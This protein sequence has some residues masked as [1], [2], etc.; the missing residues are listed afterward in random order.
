MYGPNAARQLPGPDWLRTQRM[1]AAAALD[2][3]GLPSPDEEVWRYSRI[4]ELE[5]DLYAPM[6]LRPPSGAPEGAGT[7]IDTL[8]DRAA[9]VVLHDGFVVHAELDHEVASKGAAIGAMADVPGDEADGCR[10]V[11][12]VLGMRWAKGITLLYIAVLLGC[13]L[14]VS[15]D[16]VHSRTTL[17][18]MGGLV[19]TPLLLSAGFTFSARDRR[20]HVIAANLTKFAMAAAVGYGWLMA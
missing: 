8:P 16:V 6:T 15:F 14:V 9:L 4:A 2:G 5:P 11:P 12:I 19:V 17:K 7:L 13:I 10:T 20:G 1:E 3:A 18:Y